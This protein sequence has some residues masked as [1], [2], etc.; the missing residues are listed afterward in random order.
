RHRKQQIVIVNATVVIAIEIGKVF[1]HFDAP[2]LKHFQVQIR[3]DALHFT[4]KIERVI[5]ANQREGVA[6]LKPPLLRLLRHAKRRAVLQTRKREL[7]S[8]RD[9]HR[10]VNER[11]EAETEVVQIA[12]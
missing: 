2:L 10:V 3:L 9:R 11:A 4:A 12:W 1:D 6:E 5:T 7:R 8:G